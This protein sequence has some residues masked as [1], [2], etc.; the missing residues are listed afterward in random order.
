M[1]ARPKSDKHPDIYTCLDDLLNLRLKAR[2]FHFR[3]PQPI[4]SLLTGI[5]VSS[6]RGRGLNFEE[7]RQYGIGDD[8]RALHWKVTLRTGKPYVKVYTEERERNV[9]LLIDQRQNMFF[10][11]KNKTK[12]VI[13]AELAALIGWQTLAAGD[14]IGSLVF[15]DQKVLSFVPRRSEHQMIAI[16]SKVVDF[17]HE[18]SV[19]ERQKSV[20]LN[21]VFERITHLAGHDALVVLIS[22]GQG[23]DSASSEYLKA[24][25]RHSELILCYVSDPLE[26][27]LPGMQ[28]MV[29]SDGR[30]QIQ[31]EAS[32]ASLQTRYSDNIAQQI[33]AAVTSAR[34]YRV[35]V[36]P[37][38][39]LSPTDLQLKK[40]LGAR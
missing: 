4:N 40:C 34:R 35:P 3:N 19:G 24:I 39:T 9:F 29:V 8:I 18:L 36:L 27:A 13:A 2:G 20:A 26:H 32:D 37:F 16:L 25:R 12:S 33:D 15:N 7:I 28:Q 1:A 5:H 14:R 11:S 21:D 23:W 31:V 17:N 30:L 22:D 6:L 38:E 10:G